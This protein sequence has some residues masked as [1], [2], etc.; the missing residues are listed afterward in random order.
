MLILAI[1]LQLVFGLFITQIERTEEEKYL[2][3]KWIFVHKN[4]NVICYEIS[5][6]SEFCICRNTNMSKIY[7]TERNVMMNETDATLYVSEYNLM[8]MTY[9]FWRI[10]TDSRLCMYELSYHIYVYFCRETKS[11]SKLV[12]KLLHTIHIFVH[13][14]FRFEQKRENYKLLLFS[15]NFL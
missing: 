2:N 15:Q 3:Y 4:S 1:I 7:K 6:K 12:S 13:I 10:F 8:Y 11:I 9:P 5:S 14:C